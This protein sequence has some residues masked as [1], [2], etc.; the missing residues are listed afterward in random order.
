MDEDEEGRQKR[1]DARE[2]EEEGGDA[3]RTQ[4]GRREDG[5]ERVC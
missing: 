2:E 1:D 3:G 4:A 5:D